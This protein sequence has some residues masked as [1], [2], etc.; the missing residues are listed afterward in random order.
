M[1]CVFTVFFNDLRNYNTFEKGQS[2]HAEM[3]DFAFRNDVLLGHCFDDEIQQRLNIDLRTKLVEDVF[4]SES[5]VDLHMSFN[6]LSS[7]SYTTL[8][9]VINVFTNLVTE[10]RKKGLVLLCR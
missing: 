6:G 4:E 5:V 8:N 1:L 7:T 10:L 9:R 2:T 3:F